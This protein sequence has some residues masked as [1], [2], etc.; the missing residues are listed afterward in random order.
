MDKDTKSRKVYTKR[1]SISFVVASLFSFGIFFVLPMII[2]MAKRDNWESSLPPIT[3]N[4]FP[5]G[6]VNILFVLWLGAWIYSK[7]IVYDEN[8]P[9]SRVFNVNNFAII[10]IIEVNLFFATALM[11]VLSV[12]GILSIFILTLMMIY[13]TF[14]SKNKS[15]QSLLF[16]YT[17]VNNK[18]DS[19]FK[20]LVE[21]CIKFG[22]VIV[23]IYLLCKIFSS[24]KGEI[25][26]DFM[27]ITIATVSVIVMNIIVVIGEAYLLFPYLLYGYYKEKYSE[28]YRLYEGKTQL[29]WYGEKYF[30]KHIKGTSLEE[31]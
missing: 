24:S 20:K 8:I 11:N 26:T 23:L 18:M 6:L 21:N 10:F 27:G 30:D 1:N 31:S 13:V 16:G 14:S 28:E 4:L 25:K 17:F 12:W 22:G 5:V 7:K 9:Y 2:K 15:L 3:T 29:E 19:F